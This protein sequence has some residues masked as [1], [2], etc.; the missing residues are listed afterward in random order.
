[1]PRAGTTATVMSPAAARN[2]Y[3]YS[4][5]TVKHPAAEQNAQVMLYSRVQCYTHHCLLIV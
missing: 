1:M 4:P 3:K 5:S 2:A